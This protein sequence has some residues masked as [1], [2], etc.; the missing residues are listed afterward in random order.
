MKSYPAFAIAQYVAGSVA[1]NNVP[2]V[3]FPPCCSFTLTG[4]QTF[5]PAGALKL[6]PYFHA[7][8]S[9]T[10][11]L[12]APAGAVCFAPLSLPAGAAS[13]NCVLPASG[14]LAYGSAV[15]VV[16]G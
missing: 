15:G 7:A 9:K 12:T 10:P 1:E 3:T 16:A 5:D 13:G 6:V 14:L 11:W 4:F 2:P 8:G